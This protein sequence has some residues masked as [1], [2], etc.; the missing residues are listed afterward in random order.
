MKI[1][2]SLRPDTKIAAKLDN[3]NEIKNLDNVD[4]IIEKKK[5]DKL[6]TCLFLLINKKRD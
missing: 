4:N 5:Q 2:S 6:K 1:F 3:I